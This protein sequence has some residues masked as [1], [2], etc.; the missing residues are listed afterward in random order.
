MEKTPK[1]QTLNY[2][3]HDFMTELG[4]SPNELIVYAIIYSFTKGENGVFYGSQSYIAEAAGIS[5]R[6]VIRVYKK[7]YSL[8]LIEKYASKEYKRRGIR[9]IEPSLKKDAETDE[10]ELPEI[11]KSPKTSAEIEDALPYIDEKY[12]FIE[13][14]N[15]ETLSITAEQ[16]KK[17]RELVSADTLYGYARRFDKYMYKRLGSA[18]PGPRSHYQILKKWIEEDLSS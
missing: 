11:K 5:L 1:K 9:A 12:K 18:T 14:P 7:L 2:H 6:T 17:L 8:N 15:I 4:L 13:I 3:V 10:Y 16:Y